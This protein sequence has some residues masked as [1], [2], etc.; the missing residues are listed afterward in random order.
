[1]GETAGREKSACCPQQHGNVF[2]CGPCFSS[3][4]LVS[5]LPR[6]RWQILMSIWGELLNRTSTGLAFTFVGEGG[7]RGG[8]ES[9]G[10]FYT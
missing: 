5:S 2:A 6:E 7:G 1:M 3:P 8:V 4:G 10:N 9:E